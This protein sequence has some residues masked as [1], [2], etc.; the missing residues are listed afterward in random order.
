MCVARTLD[1]YPK[2]AHLALINVSVFIKIEVGLGENPGLAGRML[3]AYRRQYNEY[4]IRRGRGA[5]RKLVKEK[6]KWKLNEERLNPRR[7]LDRNLALASY[8]EKFHP[9]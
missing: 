9:L 8:S 3:L 2:V 6:K 7:H 5:T 4:A 1:M